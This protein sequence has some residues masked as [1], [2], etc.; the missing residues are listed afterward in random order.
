MLNFVPSITAQME[1]SSRKKTAPKGDGQTIDTNIAPTPLIHRLIPC[2]VAIVTFLVLLPVLQ[3]GFVNWDDGAF[4]VDNPNARGLDWPRLRW[5][6]TTCYLGSCMPLNYVTYGLDYILWGMN[7]L[8]Y[9]LSSLLIHSVNAVVFYFLSLRLL[10]LAVP[11]SLPQL[12]YRLVAAVATLLFSLHPLRVEAVAWVLGREIAIAGFFFFLTLICYLKAA[13][14]ESIGQSRWGWMSA[15]WIFYA[16]SLLGK[17][18]ALTLPLALFVLDFYP[19][20]RFP[21]AWREWSGTKARRVWCEKVPFLLIALAAAIKAVLAKG[22]SGTIYAWENYGL[23]PRLA[24]VL[25]SFAFYLWKTLAPIELSP[26]Y[27]LRPFAGRWSLLFL[28]TGGIFLLLTVGLF[29]LRRR[30]PV[31]LAAWVFY[32]ILLLPVSGIVAFGPYVAADRFSYIP[33]ALWAVVPGTGLLW[34]WKL[35]MSA[36]ISTRVLAGAHFL[37]AGIV[38]GLAALTWH[39]SQI[40]KDSERLWRHALS[41][42]DGSSFAHNNLGL[43]LADHGALPEAVKEFRRAV[44]IDP[45]FVEAHTNLGNFLAQ[46]GSRE[47]AVA[48]LRQALQIDPMFANAHNTLGNILVDSGGL[49][50]ALQEFRKAIEINPDAAIFHYN[51]ARAL[52]KKGDAQGAISQYRQALRIDPQDFEIRN[53]LGLLLLR[54][55]HQDEATEQ[56]REAIQL[57]PRYAKAYFN[58]GKI[59]LEQA[60]LDEAAEN[61]ERALRLE[62]EVAEI[63]ENLGRVLV[64]QGRKEQATAHFAEALRILRSQR[65]SS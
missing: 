48:H 63:H 6:F 41:I 2:S 14:K 58:L 30:W 7:P 62:P 61:F 1:P 25:Y 23:L 50:E 47:E 57:N 31:G 42:D 13:E 5:M 39:Q 38:V 15:A 49:E 44:Q 12:P 28:A 24:Q 26:L 46:T 35:K 53:N 22:Q 3:N 17:E 65:P 20:K 45:V 56:F 11:S 60:R 21:G 43:V 55:G 9:H 51:L 37:T 40:W 16:L 52:A 32:A 8:G 18:A 29:I 34:A 36:R 19:L 27:P 54:Q 10:R 33:C 64:L 59:Y 4:L